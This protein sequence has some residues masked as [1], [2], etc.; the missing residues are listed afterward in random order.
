MKRS[1]ALLAFLMI[2]FP[3]AFARSQ[4]V[5]LTLKAA[6]EMAMKNHPQVVA[7][8]NAL[9]AANEHVVEARSAYYPTL[10][11]E[12]TGS[13]GNIDARIGAGAL[14]TSRLFNRFGQGVVLNQLITDVGRTPNLVANSRLQAQSSGKNYETTR[15]DV[16]LQVNQAYFDT[17]H[18]QAIVKVA[19]ETVA[20]RQLLL[21]QVSALAKNQLKSE[22]DVSFAAVNVSEAKLLLIRAQDGV[23]SAFAELARALGSDQPQNYKLLD[24]PLP[25]SPS[26]N[27]ADLVAEAVK[28]RPELASLRYSHEAAEKFFAAERDLTRP[29]VSMI[30]VAGLLPFVNQIGSTPIPEE[31]EGAAINVDI[32]I[33]NG[34]LF[35]ARR[36][37]ARYQAAEAEQKLRDEQERIVRDVNVAWAGAMNAYQRIDVTAQFL[38]QAAL[39]LNLAQGR[40]TLGLSSIVELTQGQLNLT[41]A[42]IENLAAKYDY[43]RQYS[44]LEYNVGLLR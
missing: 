25:P 14:T 34:H 17:L 15:Y 32:P 6:Q 24:E 19:E 42:E 1:A 28:N 4:P 37:A 16:L 9:G 39:A 31:Y 7:A 40:Y 29:V 33:F 11:G 38:R 22:L 23:Q 27:P 44:V 5:E 41:Q 3:A 21:D 20:A 12:L 10:D 13:Q 18:A 35:A 2:T 30:G 8:Q 26:P 36:E 43:Q